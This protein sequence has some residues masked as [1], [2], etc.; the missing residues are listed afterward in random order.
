MGVKRGYHRHYAARGNAVLTRPV[1]DDDNGF[2]L[3]PMVRGIRLTSGAEFARQDAPPT[4]V[5]IA[6]AEPIARGLFPLGET[7]D[8]QSWLG[9]RPVFPDLREAI[10]RAPGLDGVWLNFGHAHHGLT[11]GPA[12]G[13]LL[14]Q[15]IA[16]ETPY[17]DPTPYSAERFGR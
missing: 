3:A 9:S 16:G 11:L 14:A 1:V 10:G 8:A 12:T 4:P 17:T 7:V 15:M 13:L 2:V 6:R 5:Q